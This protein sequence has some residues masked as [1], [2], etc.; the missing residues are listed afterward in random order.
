MSAKPA[1]A[2]SFFRDLPRAFGRGLGKGLDLLLP[3]RCL[4]SDEIV[5]R[6]GTLAPAFWREMVFIEAPFCA[7]C[8]LPFSIPVEGE[9]LC[10]SCLEEEPA[11]DAARAAVAYNDASR[12]LILGF[13]YGDKLHAVDTFT[14][15]LLRA[16]EKLLASCDVIVPVPLHARRLWKRRFNQSALLAARLAKAAG[17]THIPDAL[18]RLRAT[19]PQKGLKRAERRDNVRGAFTVSPRHAPALAGKSILLIDDVFTSGAT[20]NECARVLKKEGRAEKT[21]VLTLA[22]VTRDEF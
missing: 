17:K 18:L 7:C 5:D 14:P 10:A 8:G 12:Q 15:W 21:C 4:G 11:F 16:G 3:P 6:P 13:K 2:A 20:L 19:I 9:M 1:P 22:R